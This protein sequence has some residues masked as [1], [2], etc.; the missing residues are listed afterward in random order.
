MLPIRRSGVL[1][2]VRG[3]E[4]ARKVPGIEDVVVTAHLDE[5]IVP[6]PEGASYLGFA[7]ARGETP[8]AVEAALR[9]AGSRIE[10]VVKPRLRVSRG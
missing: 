6:L 3:I 5:E 9:E 7:F 8:A 10:T 4:A 2:E 1:Q